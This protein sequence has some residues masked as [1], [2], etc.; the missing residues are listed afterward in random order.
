MPPKRS[1]E[2]QSADQPLPVE[3]KRSVPSDFLSLRLPT[4]LAYMQ[5]ERRQHST[6]NLSK[7]SEDP[8][9][10]MYKDP[11]NL[12]SR[13]HTLIGVF[14]FTP[15]YNPVHPGLV[16]HHQPVYPQPIV[17]QPVYSR[18]NVPQPIVPQPVYSHPIGPLTFLSTTVPEKISPDALAVLDR[19]ARY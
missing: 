19:F 16:N 11:P 7:K 15:Q 2:S 12:D 14:G 10:D 1:R 5:Q 18:P 17:P 9:D 8:E 4:I 6:T 3:P 13:H